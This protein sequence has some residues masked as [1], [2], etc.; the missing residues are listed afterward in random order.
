MSEMPPGF[1]PNDPT[2]RDRAETEHASATFATSEYPPA[3]GATESIPWIWI[4]VDN[5]GLKVLKG[6]DAFL[7][8]TCREGVTFEEIEALTKQMRDLLEGITC[9]K[10][11]T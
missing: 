5:P 10:F 7:G 9:T 3:P 2:A 8:L 6:G 11:I 4:Q 1:G